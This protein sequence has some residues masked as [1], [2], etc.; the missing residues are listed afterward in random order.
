MIPVPVQLHKPWMKE[1]G[2]R[3]KF[4]FLMPALFNRLCVRMN[5]NLML[6][7]SNMREKQHI[8]FMEN[9]LCYL[10]GSIF[11]H[12][13]IYGEDIEDKPFGHTLEV[14]V[15]GSKT[16]ASH[17][18]RVFV[19]I[20]FLIINF[21][22]ERYPSLLSM[23]TTITPIAMG[24][25]SFEGGV[26]EFPL[27][28]CY[29]SLVNQEFQIKHMDYL[30]AL[31]DLIPDVMNPDAIANGTESLQHLRG[32][33]QKDVK[34]M[35]FID[36]GVSSRVY[37]ANWRGAVVAIKMFTQS[38][39]Y[40][41]F[42]QECALLSFLRHPNIVQFKHFY[43]EPLCVVMEF[44]SGGSLD[45]YAKDL[46]NRSQKMSLKLLVRIAID[47]VRALYYLHSQ[48]PPVCHCDLKAKNVL[49]QSLDENAPIVCK[50]ADF[51]FSISTDLRN[52]HG[53]S[54]E[55][56]ITDFQKMIR[57]LLKYH[58]QSD[59]ENLSD[60]LMKLLKTPRMSVFEIEKQLVRIFVTLSQSDRDIH[61]ESGGGEGGGGSG[62]GDLE[63]AI[64]LSLLQEA[65][66]NNGIEKSLMV[67]QQ[68][69]HF[70]NDPI[71]CP[72]VH[73]IWQ[74]M[75]FDENTNAMSILL[76]LGL[77]IDSVDL[78]ME[79]GLITAATYGK[80]E[81]VD[82]LLQHGS[83]PNIVCAGN[84]TTALLRAASSRSMRCMDFLV[85]AG[86]DVNFRSRLGLSAIE[87]AALL[88][89]RKRSAEHV[90]FL[91]EKGATMPPSPP[92]FLELFLS[93][94]ENALSI[95]LKRSLSLLN[96]L[97]FS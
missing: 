1:I 54:A 83:N 12:V 50:L 3:Y 2:R 28:L 76:K 27:K 24:S 49:I 22:S 78:S 56:D 71:A 97:S 44:V 84:E 93:T 72:L 38:T 70:V 15:S 96:P 32:D 23:H 29:Q 68:Y 82:F 61:P 75:I 55:G 6:W 87:R 35:T 51:G 81:S 94:I 17:V 16:T 59:D 95:L 74:Q 8:I 69:K 26:I 48:D 41:N 33:F 10:R 20:D 11:V 13:S 37:K 7:G 88:G 67:L 80:A 63:N 62:D 9:G 53:P 4:D 90:A 21:L 66:S 85:N 52:R 73:K 64:F 91:I 47:I 77:P 34:D 19:E 79:T 58:T 14:W 45:A 39:K 25:D 31:E 36:Q 65:V 42:Y 92:S 30:F 18:R 89:E 46:E 60:Q 5:D 43:L 40:Q 86:A 57:S